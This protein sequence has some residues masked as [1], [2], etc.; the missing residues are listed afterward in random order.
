MVLVLNYSVYYM[1]KRNKTVLL[2]THIYVDAHVQN[3][4]CILLVSYTWYYNI[5]HTVWR[6]C[7][8]ISA[9]QKRSSGGH[10]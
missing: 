1:K 6:V 5:R 7:L 10:W 9:S 4:Y 2:P 8:K 3:V